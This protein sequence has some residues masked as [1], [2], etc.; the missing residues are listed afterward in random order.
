MS[1]KLGIIRLLY[2]LKS[3]S[4]DPIELFKALGVERDDK[5]LEIGCAIGYHTLPLAQVASAGKIHAV[6]IWEE[7]LAYLRD[8]TRDSKHQ[9]VETICCSAEAVQL[10]PSSLDKI[11]CFDTLHEVPNLEQAVGE[12]TDFLKDGGKFFYKDPEIPPER[13]QTLSKGKLR[14]A[15][16]TRGIHVFVRQERAKGA[17]NQPPRNVDTGRSSNQ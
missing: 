8:K 13:I 15:G 6:D 7:G 3:L 11:F 2:W 12:W 5:I 1:L 14:Q 9:N 16:T 17:D 4:E 10:P